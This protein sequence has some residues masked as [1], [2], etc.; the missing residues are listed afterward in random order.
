MS[1]LVSLSKQQKHTSGTPALPVELWSKIFWEATMIPTKNE[2]GTDPRAY[3]ETFCDPPVQSS[4]ITD[5]ELNVALKSRLDIVLVCKYW[6]DIGLPILYSHLLISAKL[7]DAAHQTTHQTLAGDNRLTDSVCRVT[8]VTHVPCLEAADDAETKN[9]PERHRCMISILGL[10]PHLRIVSASSMLFWSLP[11]SSRSSVAVADFT[12]SEVNHPN[13]TLSPDGW[14]HLVHLAL[15]LSALLTHECH[16]DTLS[17]S[18]PSLISL[19]INTGNKTHIPLITDISNKWHAPK[20]DAFW[21]YCSEW[22]PWLPFLAKHAPTLTILNIRHIP[23]G[24]THRPLVHLPNLRQL[25]LEGNVALHQPRT[26]VDAPHLER[27]VVKHLQYPTVPDLLK[28]FLFTL[29]LGFFDRVL[30]LWGTA[31]PIRTYCLSVDDRLF[32]GLLSLSRWTESVNILRSRGS[33]VVFYLD[34]GGCH[35]F[36]PLS[37]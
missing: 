31:E 36:E 27:V 29:Q 22:T 28:S 23:D 9:L 13:Q 25:L 26:L 16:E 15:D 17:V 3:I 35:V 1:S 4:Q 11:P 10:L 32:P 14:D 33:E 37:V 12:V 8:V 6:R 5:E 18:F 21:I 19:D 34:E 24:F 2:F 30:T 7:G 20:L